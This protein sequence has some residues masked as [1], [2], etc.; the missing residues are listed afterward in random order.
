MYF[1]PCVLAHSAK[2]GKV[3]ILLFSSTRQIPRLIVTFKC[4]YCP[5]GLA[6]ALIKYLMANEMKSYNSWKLLHNRVF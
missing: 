3:H 1:F 4:G 2:E 6:R 5:K